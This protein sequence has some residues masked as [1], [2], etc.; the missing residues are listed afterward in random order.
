MTSLVHNPWVRRAAVALLFVALFFGLRAW[1]Q[2]TLV[3]GTAPSLSALALNGDYPVLGI[4][5]KPTL[6]YF[7]ASWCG[8]CKLEE[9]AMES[10]A[11]DHKVISVA[12]TSG[13]DAEVRRYLASRGLKLPVINDPDGKIANQWGV[14]VTPTSFIVDTRNRI[15]FREVGYTTEWGF[16]FRLWLARF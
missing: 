2:R 7:W 12:L 10:I 4:G 3:H 9:G 5:T 16:R 1:Q 14:R 13:D 8:V 11:R 15:R 6:V